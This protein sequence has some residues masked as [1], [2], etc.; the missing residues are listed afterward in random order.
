[1]QTGERFIHAPAPVRP[2]HVQRLRQGRVCRV[3]AEP[4]DGQSREV[5]EPR[6]D[7]GSDPLQR[8]ALGPATGPPPRAWLTGGRRAVI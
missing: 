7:T 8:L 6:I 2:Q 5:A 3:P 4:P 1:M